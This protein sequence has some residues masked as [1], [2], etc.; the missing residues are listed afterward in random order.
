MNKKILI[1]IILLIIFI[2]PAST[3]AI[4]GLMEENKIIETND[5]SSDD[6]FKAYMATN[7]FTN[8]GAIAEFEKNMKVSLK[9]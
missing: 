6:F 1:G 7:D 3:Y 4:W 5:G 2:V 9:R 8:Q